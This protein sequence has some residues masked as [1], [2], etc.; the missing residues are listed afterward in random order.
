MSHPPLTEDAASP[1]GSSHEATWQP[2]EKF[3][4]TDGGS[5]R[6]M[7]YL[8]VL[9]LVLGAVI[10]LAYAASKNMRRTETPRPAPAASGA[11]V[12]TF[13]IETAAKPIPLKEGSAGDAKYA[14]L[15]A[16][17]QERFAIYD[18]L[19][20]GKPTGAAPAKPL[21]SV[22]YSAGMSSRPP[23]GFSA[24][25]PDGAQAVGPDARQAGAGFAMPDANAPASGDVDGV[26]DLLKPSVLQ[27]E[28]AA[29]MPNRNFLLA[30]G[31][32]LECVLETAIDT[33]LPGLVNCILSRDIYGDNARVLLLEKGS[34][35]TGEYRGSMRNGQR[36]LF[37]IWSRIVTPQGV[38]IRLNSPGIDPLGRAGVDGFLENRYFERFGMALLVS[39][40]AD[41]IPAVIEANVNKATEGQNIE[42]QM[43]GS[44]G[45]Q[46]GSEVLRQNA[47]VPPLLRKNQ[48]DIVSV[49]V[50]RDLDFSSIYSL[51]LK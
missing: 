25:M 27:G 16:M 29:K 19:L 34:K 31:S 36:R 2:R 38:A 41:A 21:E 10:W 12:P 26:G 39:I 35:L 51:R 50:A 45:Q 1:Y 22:I 46:M 30:K 40:V 7:I 49:M 32:S 44:T 13:R 47:L 14:Q 37:L 17:L 48:G 20:A 23:P 3:R 33:S 6:R 11:P 43:T 28:S 42:M 8:V 24:S 5:S 18:K 9:M 15:M 4:R